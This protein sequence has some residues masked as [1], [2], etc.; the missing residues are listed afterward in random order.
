MAHQL[1]QPMT[2]G[3]TTG[4]DNA[5]PPTIA[6]TAQP[7]P[8]ASTAAAMQKAPA[9]VREPAPLNGA[10]GTTATPVVIQSARVLERMGQSEMHVG[11]N[12]T[13]FGSIE[14]HTSVN[15]NRVGASIATSHLELRA[16]MLAEVPS[17]ER[18]MAQHQL[19]LDNLNLDAHAGAQHGDGSFA[20][21]P[22]RNQ[23]WAQAA[24][25]LGQFG[26][27]RIATET[28]LSEAGTASPYA[29]LNV[30]A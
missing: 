2:P 20:G 9:T 22:S 5:A 16:A 10:E 17:L 1:A 12:T 29:G 23:N 6:A 24:E 4:Q 7:Q 21:H 14:L 13:N 18:A 15:E 27:D 25:P 11:V 8:A 28:P 30:H 19:R 26:D 3:A